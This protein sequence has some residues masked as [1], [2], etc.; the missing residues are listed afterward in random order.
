MLCNHT[1]NLHIYKYPCLHP[2]LFMSPHRL[3]VPNVPSRHTGNQKGQ[4]L[5]T[6][7]RRNGVL[8]PKA[9]VLTGHMSHVWSGGAGSGSSV[10]CHRAEPTLL[11]SGATWLT[12]ASWEAG[13]NR[14]RLWGGVKALS[15][16]AVPEEDRGKEEFPIRRHILP[17]LGEGP[18]GGGTRADSWLG[19]AVGRETC[20]H[21]LLTIC[22]TVDSPHKA[23]MHSG[24]HGPLEDGK[25]SREHGSREHVCEISKLGAHPPPKCNPV[26]SFKPSPLQKAE[27]EKGKGKRDWVCVRLY[28]EG[29]NII[30]HVMLTTVFI[31]AL[32]PFSRGRSRPRGGNRPTQVY[33]LTD[34]RAKLFF[35]HTPH[36][37]FTERE[38]ELVSSRTYSVGQCDP[39]TSLLCVNTS[40]V[41]QG[42]F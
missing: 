12:T 27:L 24:S 32:R 16:L 30:S 37:H 34:S 39:A 31:M 5:R 17:V 36:T 15:D 1:Y 3:W 40:M 42:D 20:S 11:P 22:C 21:F 23:E 25:A 26:H 41:C 8:A 29:I 10:S 28:S 38:T 9:D 14:A 4:A 2:W 33:K 6:A 7:G 35:Y 13:G 19:L 18:G